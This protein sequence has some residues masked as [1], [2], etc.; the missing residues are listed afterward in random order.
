MARP[1]VLIGWFVDRLQMLP[2]VFVDAGVSENRKVGVLPKNACEGRGPASM[3]S[4]NEDQ[5]VA[6]DCRVQRRPSRHVEPA[7]IVGVLLA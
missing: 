5:P 2:L 6:T 7:I 1:A 4:T 3:Q